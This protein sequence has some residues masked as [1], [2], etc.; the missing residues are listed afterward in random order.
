MRK[1]RFVILICL[2][3]VSGRAAVFQADATG[4]SAVSEGGNYYYA[5]PGGSPNGDGSYSN[6]WDLGTALGRTSTA[7]AGDTI[8]LRGG[9]YTGQ[10]ESRLVGTAE[11]PVIVRSFPGEWAVI[12]TQ[13]QLGD[14]SGFHVY[15]HHTYYWDFE[16]TNSNTQ[17]RGGENIETETCNNKFINLIVHDAVG[18]NF[19]C[20][21]EIYGCIFYNNGIDGSGNS[22]QFYVQNDDINNPMQLIDNIIF[23]SYA[24]NIHVYSGGVSSLSGIELRGNVVFNSGV[25]ASNPDYRKDNFLIGGV[26]GVSGILL[27]EN[28]GWAPSGDHRS[29]SFGKYSDL[30]Q[31]ISLTGNQLIGETQFFN[32]WDSIQMEGNTFFLLHPD[33]ID[34]SSYPDNKYLSSRPEG[35]ETFV[36]QNHYDTRRAHVIVYNWDLD[37]V[38][39]LDLSSV[40]AT[41]ESFEIRNAQNYFSAPVY[42]GIFDGSPVSLPMAGLEPAMPSAPG[43]IDPGEYTGREFNV[44][45]LLKMGLAGGG[46]T[47]IPLVAFD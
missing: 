29:A 18:N 44:F 16:I 39:D 2:L 24:F 41:G 4:Y 42:S 20:G 37:E 12:D 46:K 38:V 22:H 36:R 34:P 30:N 35:I 5:S 15:S 10:V 31:D 6:P 1:I 32:S 28:M 21:N 9:T 33:G 25:A 47:F 13:Q 3:L 45:V 11:N 43:S 19:T 7:Q 27:Q 23:N 26:N 40:L 17:N 8:W 14:P